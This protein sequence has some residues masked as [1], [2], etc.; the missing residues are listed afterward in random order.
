MWPYRPVR[1]TEILDSSEV[2]A[3]LSLGAPALLGSGVAALELG[4]DGEA[5]RID[6]QLDVSASQPSPFCG[7]LRH[8]QSS[9]KAAFEGADAACERCEARFARRVLESGKS[10]LSG[11]RCHMGLQDLAAPVVIEGR[12]LAVLVAGQRVEV[13]EGRNRIAKAVGKLGKLTRAEVR[14]LEESSAPVEPTISVSDESARARLL[15][16]IPSI[17][18]LTPEFSLRLS[19]LAAAFASL[20]QGRMDAARRRWEDAAVEKLGLLEPWGAGERPPPRLW[21]YNAVSGLHRLIEN[22]F[23]AVFAGRPESDDRRLPLVVH[24]G[25]LPLGIAPPARGSSALELDIDELKTPDAGATDAVGEGLGAVSRL[26]SAVHVP[27]GGSHEGK[28]KLTK[29]VFAPRLRV[30]EGHDVVVAFGA[31][32]SGL[33]PRRDDLAFLW[34][35]SFLIAERYCLARIESLRRKASVRLGRFEA[36]EEKRRIERERRR[37]RPIQPQRFDLRRLLDQCLG[38]VEGACK[39]RSVRIDAHALPERLM[40]EADRPKLAAVFEFLLGFA[41][42][43]AKSS[44]DGDRPAIVLSVR[45]EGREGRRLAV[46]VDVVGEYLSADERRKLFAA[47]PPQAG[48]GDA[49]APTDVPEPS[50]PVLTFREAQR[51]VSIHGGRLQLESTRGDAIPGTDGRWSGRTVFTVML[52]MRPPVEGRPRSKPPPARSGAKVQNVRPE[53]E[54]E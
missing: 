1:L 50:R 28:D 8:G 10:E 7:F 51:L 35:A 26:I 23:V 37:S 16:A 40:L 34:R 36:A 4:T 44:S 5:S 21:L 27:D 29:S 15:Q 12:V 41:V 9:G 54:P 25:L 32:R 19:Q 48:G 14:S 53:H 49:P 52:W 6:P 22:D 24:S 33:Q 42:G 13:D 20:V 43:T 18:V 2:G 39:E 46:V 45:R 17:P 11:A 47:A 30:L 38:L 3:L 31:P